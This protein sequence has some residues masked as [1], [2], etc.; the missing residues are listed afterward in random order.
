MIRHD[1]ALAIL[2]EGAAPS[3]S[4]RFELDQAGGRVAAE[5]VFSPVDLPLFE[6]SAMDGFAVSSDDVSRASTRKPVDLEIVGESRA[7]HPSEPRL[8][9]G[10]AVGISTGAMV[11]EGAD[12]VIRI[13]DVSRE[14][15][16][17]VVS[18]AVDSGRDIRRR[19]EIAQAG[20][21]VFRAGVRL[22]PIELGAL[23]TVGHG[24]VN[25]YRRPRVT[26]LQREGMSGETGQRVNPVT[27]MV[28]AMV[29][30]SGAELVDSGSI[31]VD[32]D[33]TAEAVRMRPESDLILVCSMVPAAG[34]GGSRQVDF[35]ANLADSRPVRRPWVMRRGEVRML[36]LPDENYS[37][38]VALRLLVGPLVRSLSGVGVASIP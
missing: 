9:P 17:L 5:D 38:E 2:L 23:A 26:L 29:A 28:I 11:P 7:G 10:Q 35:G 27:Q 6:N 36:G 21:C 13:E 15:S 30:E 34:P 3:G 1:S 18:S 16:R 22:G 37:A 31:D 24:H 12:A 32:R 14:G 4:E 25:C 8:T 33:L 19:G 20:S